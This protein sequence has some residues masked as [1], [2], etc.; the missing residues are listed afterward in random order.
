MWN[1]DTPSYV[2]IYYVESGYPLLYKNIVCGMWITLLYIG[3]G[4][5][6]RS[7][8]DRACYEN[9]GEHCGQPHQTVVVN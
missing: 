5:L 9:P 6:P 8:A 3:K 7:Q 1:V 4:Q 2:R